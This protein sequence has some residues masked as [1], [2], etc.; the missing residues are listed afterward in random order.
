MRRLLVASLALYVSACAGPTAVGDR[1]AEAGNYDAAIEAYDESAEKPRTSEE[2]RRIYDARGDAYE[3]LLRQE[4]AEVLGSSMS[5]PQKRERLAELYAQAFSAAESPELGAEIERASVDVSK[6]EIDQIRGLVAANQVGAAMDQLFA[7]FG[8]VIASE[9]AMQA[10]LEVR[11]E[12]AAAIRARAE[13]EAQPGV[14]QLL[15]AWADRLDYSPF[16]ADPYLRPTVG[17]ASEQ[18]VCDQPLQLEG[19]GVSVSVSATCETEI[20]ITEASE[21]FNYGATEEQLA[22]RRVCTKEIDRYIV[23]RRKYTRKIGYDVYQEVLETYSVPTYETVCR[24]EEYVAVVDVVRTGTRVFPVRVLT[25]RVRGSVTMKLPLGEVTV[26]LDA[27]MSGEVRSVPIADDSPESRFPLDEAGEIADFKSKTVGPMNRE[28]ARLVRE[29]LRDEQIGR[30]NLARANGD[31]G[32]TR[33][34]L[35][36]AVLY[37]APFPAELSDL[38]FFDN[39][40]AV[41]WLQ[42]R[43]I[44]MRSVEQ[45]TITRRAASADERFEVGTSFMRWNF[46]GKH[47]RMHDLSIQPDRLGAMFE[48]AM[49][50][51]FLSRLLLLEAW[52]PYGFVL[53]DELAYQLSMGRR[54][55]GPTWQYQS[56]FKSSELEERWSANG[57]GTSGTVLLGYRGRAVGLLAGVR[58][59][60]MTHRVG[61]AVAGSAGVPAV[62]R[63]ELAPASRHPFIAEVWGFSPVGD[64]KAIGGELTVALGG[65]VNFGLQAEYLN[66]DTRI[67]GVSRSDTV[68]LGRRDSFTMGAML[69]LAG[70]GGW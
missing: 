54:I 27:V 36:K 6:S 18:R 5:A 10:T 55:S 4:L 60:A 9:H 19:Q 49:A 61:G 64:K 29:A 22:T 62:L 2:Q 7:L 1:L 25:A 38:G 30:A 37:G 14:K 48:F 43:D 51:S 12:A 44:Q 67:R 52:D 53:H 47:I 46:T 56:G 63:L 57:A 69:Q 26:P 41:Q 50:F 13:N 8:G 11:N 65:I 17:A 59:R 68:D 23:K 33:D 24:D 66:A 15:D 20:S 28:L 42:G 39:E 70:V 21:P 32:A 58:G 31:V 35:A 16:S 45:V 34:A 3:A 40:Q